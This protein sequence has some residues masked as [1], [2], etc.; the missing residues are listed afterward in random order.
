MVPAPPAHH[1]PPGTA[2]QRELLAAPAPDPGAHLHDG[3]YLRVGA[4]LG[5][6]NGKI[7]SDALPGKL[8]L[9]GV[10]LAVDVAA[11]LSVIPGWVIGG[12]AMVVTTYNPKLKDSY[13]TNDK[14]DATLYMLQFVTDIYPMPAK[15]LHFM[16][17]VG[18]MTM[19]IAQDVPAGQTTTYYY[20][21]SSS[22]NKARST[23]S[24]LALSLGGGW[25]TW[26]SKQWSL[27]GLI[28]LNFA[29][30][31]QDLEL[32]TGGSHPR[33]SYGRAKLSAFL[34]TL[35]FTGAFN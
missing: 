4:G 15:G 24:G 1:Q 34:P 22:D 35:A 13:G 10:G 12:R 20:S 33:T 17:G 21:G 11:G 7:S 18:P 31:E 8:T 3:F 26:V 19:E 5:Y 6:L 23:A 9:S 30:M 27:G 2:P 25:E 16:A 14:V 29:W 28:M 32:H